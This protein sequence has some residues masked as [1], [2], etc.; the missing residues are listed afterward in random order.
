[1]AS[2]ARAS[3]A[4]VVPEFVRVRCARFVGEQN[5]SLVYVRTIDAAL[6]TQDMSGQ[7]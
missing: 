1:M 7:A 3:S 6:G 4:Q 5:I 2:Y